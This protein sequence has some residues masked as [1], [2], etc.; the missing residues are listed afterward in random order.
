MVCM[1]NSTSSNE[2]LGVCVQDNLVVAQV[3]AHDAMRLGDYRCEAIVR[4]QFA[5]LLALF[6]RDVTGVVNVDS[7]NYPI[8]CVAHFAKIAALMLI[9]R[10]DASIFTEILDLINNATPGVCA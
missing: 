8:Q 6:V 7:Q 2:R 1:G 3:S 9:F 10:L 4:E 5:Q